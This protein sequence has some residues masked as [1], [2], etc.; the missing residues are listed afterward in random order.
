MKQLLYHQQNEEYRMYV[1]KLQLGK[2]YATG[3]GTCEV[4]EAKCFHVPNVD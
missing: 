4:H 1:N 3:C 2:N